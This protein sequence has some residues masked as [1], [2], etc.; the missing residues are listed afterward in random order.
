VPVPMPLPV[1][2]NGKRFRMAA[3]TPNPAGHDRATELAEQRTE[4]A[5]ER[6]RIA[7]D[8]TLMAWIRTALSM[9]TF[10]FTLYKFLEAFREAEHFVARRPNSP[11][12]LGLALIGVGTAAL[13]VATIQHYQSLKRL[14]S[15]G[16]PESIWSL[17]IIVA[18]FIALIGI[19]A[20]VGVWLRAGPF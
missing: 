12:N 4:L 9:I 11:R 15:E 14:E 20:F 5:F 19:M 2:D 8:R 6:T 10:G 13:I 3:S 16:R 1:W 7:A 18:M 17:T